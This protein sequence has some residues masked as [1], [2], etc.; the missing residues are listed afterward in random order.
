MM[1]K[2]QMI[3]QMHRD[4]RMILYSDFNSSQPEP[5]VVLVTEL[6]VVVVVSVSGSGE[7]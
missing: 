3:T 2:V 4:S 7:K 1:A 6:A 5:P